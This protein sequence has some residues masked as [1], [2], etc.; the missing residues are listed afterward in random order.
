MEAL[1]L[2]LILQLLHVSNFHAVNESVN[3]SCIPR[4]DNVWS[5][6]TFH[7]EK[8]YS[9]VC[10][11]SLVRDVS[12]LFEFVN[13]VDTKFVWTTSGF[14][15]E[16]KVLLISLRCVLMCESCLVFFWKYVYQTALKFKIKERIVYKIRFLNYTFLTTTEPSYLCDLISLQPLRSTR[17]SDVVI[18]A[19]PLCYF[20]LKVNSRSFRH[21]SPRLWN[22]LPK[23]LRQPVDD[24]SLSLSSHLSLIGSSSTPLSSCIIPSLFHSR[25]KTFS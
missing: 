19:R 23:D 14:R 18:L 4:F 3:C 6:S 1:L 11:S 20:S 7:P 22:K 15:W 25:L 9:T 16:L 17:S 5:A 13:S 8:L 24:E 10:M 21:A 12:L 2:L